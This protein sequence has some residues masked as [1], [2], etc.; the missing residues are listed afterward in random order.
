MRW[1]TSAPSVTLLDAEADT[2][3][4]QAILEPGVGETPLW[5]TLVLSA[6]FPA[7]SNALLLLA[8]LNRSIRNWTGATAASAPSRM[9]TGNGPA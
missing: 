9:R 7:D 1:R 4:E 6:L 5:D 2:S 3:N 8:A